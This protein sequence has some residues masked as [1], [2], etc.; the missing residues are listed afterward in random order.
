MTYHSL[1]LGDLSLLHAANI[2][3]ERLAMVA[4]KHGF[5]NYLLRDAPN[6]DAKDSEFIEAVN[7][8]PDDVDWLTKAPKVLADVVESIVGAVFVDFDRNFIFFG[9]FSACF[10]SP[11]T[12]QE[13]LKTIYSLSSKSVVKRKGSN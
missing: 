2:C 6:L 3:T 5:Y 1:P 13:P 4:V 8:S 9:M 10:L 7:E 11:S 12:S